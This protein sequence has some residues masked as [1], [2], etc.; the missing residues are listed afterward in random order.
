MNLGTLYTAASPTD[1]RSSDVA[2]AAVAVLLTLLGAQLI[3]PVYT[4]LAYRF[5]W[6]VQVMEAAWRDAVR[7]DER[8][9][10]YLASSDESSTDD[11]HQEAVVGE[12]VPANEIGAE[13]VFDKVEWDESTGFATLYNSDDSSGSHSD[14]SSE[15]TPAFDVEV[16][17]PS[18]VDAMIK[19]HMDAPAVDST[20][21]LQAFHKQ[22]SMKKLTSAKIR[23][24]VL[25]AE[26]VEATEAASAVQ[27]RF[28]S[29]SAVATAAARLRR[30]SRKALSLAKKRASVDE[31]D[32]IVNDIDVDGLISRYQAGDAMQ[33]PDA[34]AAR[35]KTAAELQQAQEALSGEGPSLVDRALLHHL[36]GKPTEDLL[37]H[38]EEDI[39]RTLYQGTIQDAA[40]RRRHLAARK[41]RTQESAVVASLLDQHQS[42]MD[43]ARIDEELEALPDVSEDFLASEV[44]DSFAPGADGE[45]D[46]G[47]LQGSQR[48]ASTDDI[49]RKVKGII[50]AA[51]PS[52]AAGSPISA[53]KSEAD[54]LI[55]AHLHGENLDT[56]ESIAERQQ[57]RQKDLELRRLQEESAVN[58]SEKSEVAALLLSFEEGDGP[59]SGAAIAQTGQDTFAED[60]ER[61]IDAF[62]ADPRG[63]SDRLDALSKVGTSK[64]AE[65]QVDVIMTRFATE[66]VP[67]AADSEALRATRAEVDDLLRDQLTL[68]K[69]EETKEVDA[70]LSLQLVQDAHAAEAVRKSKLSRDAE[71]R[72]VDGLLQA[73]LEEQKRKEAALQRVEDD[74]SDVLSYFTR[75]PAASVSPEASKKRRKKGKRSG[76]ASHLT[77]ESEV[78]SITISEVSDLDDARRGEGDLFMRRAVPALAGLSPNTSVMPGVS[79]DSN[80]VLGDAL[81]RVSN[82]FANRRLALE[83]P[84]T[85][86]SATPRV[87]RHADDSTGGES[88]IFE[89]HFVQSSVEL[90]PDMEATTPMPNEEAPLPT[91]EIEE[92]WIIQR[93]HDDADVSLDPDRLVQEDVEVTLRNMPDTID[94]IDVADIASLVSRDAPPP[95]YTTGRPQS[96]D[97]ATYSLVTSFLFD[98]N[99]EDTTGEK[100]KKKKKKKVSHVRRSSVPHVAVPIPRAQD[101]F[102]SL[103]TAASPGAMS[104]FEGN[105]ASLGGPKLSLRVL[106]SLSG[107]GGNTIAS[108][109]G[110]DDIELPSLDSS[111]LLKEPTPQGLQLWAGAT[112]HSSDDS[113]DTETDSSVS[114]QFEKYC[115]VD[116][117][118]D[119]SNVYV[120]LPVTTHHVLAGTALV[121]VLAT[122]LAALYYVLQWVGASALCSSSLKWEL[123][124][125][126][127]AIDVCVVDPAVMAVVYAYRFVTSNERNTIWRELHPY[128][129]ERR[130]VL[131]PPLRTKYKT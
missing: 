21:L 124:L 127:F 88:P 54:L 105:T 38:D 98:S 50:A 93:P 128:D 13:R 97:S 5:T 107:G 92:L 1:D 44:A 112:A 29:I 123:L 23:A 6:N 94:D 67:R 87:Q 125:A 30:Q 33:L 12:V 104:E 7:R 18:S 4:W 55:E 34:L 35:S 115:A 56:L 36:D 78:P 95:R 43:L 96:G 83:T 71:T 60:P 91:T 53:P 8:W 72:D 39:A 109:E 102:R 73:H 99:E 80:D 113:G 122:V 74:V 68:H 31:G 65:L 79:A 2:H 119:D 100:K 9:H 47:T 14:A 86:P 51:R 42:G 15:D 3:R 10:A 26:D 61:I 58:A 117:G 64:N 19:F 110:I 75:G 17:D 114:H 121:C 25:Q 120:D 108:L 24:A 62:I 103:H 16:A 32:L 40:R 130:P 101:E 20:E 66:A 41:H 27:G 48:R 22:Q 63:R 131:L 85:S 84:R 118:G 89:R 37:A 129:G 82:P 52:R 106:D 111:V 28:P 116:V 57:R 45:L 126:L 69:S 59:S 11:G 90:L 49:R 70:L 81:L 76:R 46:A 77:S